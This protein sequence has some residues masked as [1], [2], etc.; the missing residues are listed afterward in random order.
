MA[1]EDWDVEVFDVVPYRNSAKNP[2]TQ[3][4]IDPDGL[5]MSLF[6]MRLTHR[7]SGKRLE[8]AD[9][10]SMPTEEHLKKYARDVIAVA[11]ANMAVQ[12][13]DETDSPLKGALDVSP[14]SVE[15]TQDQKDAAVLQTAEQVKARLEALAPD[16]T[17]AIAR[18][19]ALIDARRQPVKAAE[20]KALKERLSQLETAAQEADAAVVTP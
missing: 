10:H 11:E 16:D 3:L 18:A 14:P 5:T 6:T 19:Q 20:I 2:H 17:D 15:P 8:R 13:T 12:K 1:F 7:A 4:P 9:L